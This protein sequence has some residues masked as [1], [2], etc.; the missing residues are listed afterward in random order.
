[1]YEVKVEISFPARHQVALAGAELEPLH[2]HDW[3]V[4]ARLAG[5]K[6]FSDGLLVDFTIIKQLLEKIADKLRGKD[7]TQVA[8]FN[9]QN[10]SAENV[11]RYFCEQLKGQFDP[12]VTLIGVAVQEAPGCWAAYQP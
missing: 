12:A 8:A 1:M 4:R 11:A 2:E 7:L 5:P 3:T 6:L 10:P 9:G